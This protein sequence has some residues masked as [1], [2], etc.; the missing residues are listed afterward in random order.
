MIGNGSK[1]AE[2][3]EMSSREEKSM[4]DGEHSGRCLVLIVCLLAAILSATVIGPKVSSPQTA[5]YQ[6]FAQ[7]LDSKKQ[8]V[9]A[10]AGSAT[11]ACA[12]I[13][14][15]P[16]DFGTPIANKLA[17]L[18]V[19]FLFIL[20]ALY[21]EKFLLS[22]TG[23]VV[24]ELLIPIALILYAVSGY[25]EAAIRPLA[26][27]LLC[28][29]VIFALVAPV[30]IMTSDLVEQQHNAEIQQTIEQVNSEVTDISG[31]AEQADSDNSSVWSKFIQT[32]KGGSETLL[33]KLKGVL[34][35]FVD[36]IAIYIV[37]TCVIPV[38]CLF[39]AGWLMKVLFQI[40]IPVA[41]RMIPQEVWRHMPSQ[42]GKN[43]ADLKRIGHRED[44]AD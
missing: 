20:C 26:K 30:S 21:I 9:E 7:S 25:T 3:K 6:H 10:M 35:S 13:S 5:A 37:T 33:N 36:L 44:D 17:D 11:A 24:F 29:S 27:K 2:M 39:I 43:R 1:R 31:A 22:L 32:V 38:V 15:M 14:L 8:T 40:E 4:R 19:C 42:R 28:F 34:N 23:V 18:S 41:A 12:V 16:G